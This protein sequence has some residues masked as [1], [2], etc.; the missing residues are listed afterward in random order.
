M[1]GYWSIED[2]L[3]HEELWVHGP[4]ENFF[5][6]SQELEDGRVR[7]LD[8]VT[9]ALIW[10]LPSIGFDQITPDNLEEVFL[11]VRMFEL[12]RQPMLSMQGEPRFVSLK[13]LRRR[14]GLKVEGE[15][16][17]IPFDEGVIAALRQ[18]ARKS[19]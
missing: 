19:L 11:R 8:S 13:D 9:V 1:A 16:P 12:S 14:V 5:T 18:K 15:M 10:M 6:P 4:P 2:I 17:S 3:D 7:S